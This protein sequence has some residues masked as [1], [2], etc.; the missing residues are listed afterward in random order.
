MSSLK[1][2]RELRDF[3]QVFAAAGKKCY[4]VGGALRD[5]LLGR[6]VS[7]YDAAT[8]ARP[9]EVQG[10]FRKVIP[11]GI[12]HGTVTVL[13]KG[14][15][16]ETTTFRT[17][18]G[19]T[20]ARR[21]DRVAFGASLE[22]DLERRDF[23]IN[24]MAFDPL[25][26]ELVDLHGGRD[27]LA[28]RLI[29]AVG[30]PRKRFDED[31]LRTLR[32]IRFASQLGFEIEEATLAAIPG[33]LARLS[34]VSAERLREELEK[35]LL[36]PKPSR[37]LRIMES[38]GILAQVLPE[39]A[40][41]RGV[42][43]KGL[44]AFDVLDH[45]YASVDAAAA[46]EESGLELRLAALLHDIGKPRSKAIGEDG[47]PTFYRHEEY[48]ARMAG[49][50][51]RRLRFPNATME[52]VVHLVAQHM[53]FYDESWTDAAVRRFIARVGRASLE[54]LFELRWADSSGMAGLAADPRALD[55][56]R[57]RIEAVLAA[58]DAL[59]IR[60][61]AIGGE[62]LAGIGV[63]KGP[64]MGRILSELLE[65]VLDDPAQNTREALLGI[66]SRIK[67][68]YGVAP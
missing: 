22:E 55:P 68:K 26:E 43:Q 59:G 30:E 19:Y 63:P 5:S 17:E 24:A 13:W 41:C 60:D 35:I 34:G 44:H 4:F 23:T 6:P 53:F 49:E 67:A 7:D 32:A 45:L 31:G 57:R 18:A 51:M 37:G 25:A 29:R 64:A 42:E 50:L 14:H 39:L 48:S 46:V 47:I 61:L 40:A 52:T 15:S 58:E 12:K 1:I 20:D 10:L 66:A 21:P 9:E 11:T 33:A 54:G 38:T 56:L 62:D 3:A 8:D 2:P 16:I 27:D 28:A 36:S 65:T